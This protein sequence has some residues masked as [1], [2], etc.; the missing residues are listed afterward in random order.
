[1]AEDQGTS[2]DTSTAPQQLLQMMTGYWVSQG[3]YVAA[4]LG[5]AD[6]LAA[7]PV[8]Y[9]DLAG[10]THTHAPSLYRIVRALASVGVFVELDAGHFALTPM[11]SLLQ[12][13]VPNSMRALAIMYGEEQYRAWGSLLQSV[14]T[15]QPAFDR[16]FGM[17]VFEYFRQNPEAGA[18]FN[19]AMTNWTTQASAAVAAT[20]DFSRF[21]SMI[22][23][24]GNQGTLLATI[25][26]QYPTARGAL[27][28]LP[29]VVA[30]AK[31]HLAKAGVDNRCTI[32][33]GD[34]FKA[35]PSGGDA[36][37]LS[38]VLHDWDDERCVA[39]LAQCRKAIAPN[40][41]LLVIEMVLPEGNEPSF[42]KWLDLHVLVMASGRER[43][44]EQYRALLLVGGF[45]LQR[46]I[47]T[48]AGSSIVEATPA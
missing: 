29:H 43:T 14:R 3:V 34:F 41:T 5:I 30:T 24:G 38:Y 25:L 32:L 19:E 20:Y 7:G 44:A 46:L 6:L 47:P 13:A 27:F 42:G 15:G 36:Y 18:I 40:G 16:Q 28:D 45:N 9:E 31:D 21:G 2:V 26:R 22:D 37:L 39:I 8:H 17:D 4:K 35:V 1:M 23:V 11:A 48:P 33:G 10:K 12:T